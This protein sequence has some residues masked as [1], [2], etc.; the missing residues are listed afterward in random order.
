MKKKKFNLDINKKSKLE[1]DYRSKT[2][3]RRLFRFVFKIFVATLILNIAL[4]PLMASA[5]SGT[6]AMTFEK[7]LA[8]KVKFKADYSSMLE[9]GNEIQQEIA[10]NF[11]S[12]TE[13]TKWYKKALKNINNT[14]DGDGA[15][16]FAKPNYAAILDDP[17]LNSENASGMSES[18]SSQCW[19]AYSDSV[20]KLDRVLA[21]G[22]VSNLV[23][24][25]FDTDAFDPTNSLVI[26]FMQSFKNAMNTLFDSCA[27]ILMF[28]F[29]G[30]TGADG[31][32]LI[33][34]GATGWIVARGNLHGGGAG[35]GSMGGGVGSGKLLAIN[36]VSD[37][38]IEASNGSTA[39]VGHG[40]G[41]GAKGF[42]SGNKFFKYLTLRMPIV[43]FVATYLT[44]VVT[45]LWPRLISWLAGITAQG[46][47]SIV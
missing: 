12:A 8:G 46:L 1:V 11:K 28:L 19:T 21:R 41:G 34:P 44:L 5:D 22:S 6:N 43:L 35:S 17:K 20:T 16:F 47:Y 13:Y 9:N 24:D 38:C 18:K 31:L 29:L 25:I 7:D 45:G 36:L 14:A 37:E 40:G 4:T 26:A 10:A 42:I 32:Y 23:G 3:S 30:Q 15:T 33:A 27:K 2:T 39:S